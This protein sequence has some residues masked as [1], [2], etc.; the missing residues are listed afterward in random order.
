MTAW[1]V[2]TVP[3]R[4]F[5]DEVRTREGPEQPPRRQAEGQH[6]QRRVL[7][8]LDIVGVDHCRKVHDG[9]VQQHVAEVEG[10][11]TDVDDCDEVLLEGTIAFRVDSERLLL[12]LFGLPL[13]IGDV[14]LLEIHCFGH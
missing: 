14:F 10:R 8:H 3:A 6:S 13:F 12:Q 2:R 11:E 7:S 4:Q 9:Q 1:I 5:A